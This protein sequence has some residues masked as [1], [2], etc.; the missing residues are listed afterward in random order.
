MKVLIVSKYDKDGGAAVAAY[1][2]HKSLLSAGMNSQMLV[3]KKTT[4]DFTV[5]G[6][7]W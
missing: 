2:L 1:R 6:A 7:V 4:D 3:Q 5:V